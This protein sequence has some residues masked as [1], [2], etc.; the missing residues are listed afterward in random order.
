MLNFF[1]T[2]L[3][4]IL[5]LGIGGFHTHDD[6]NLSIS[7]PHQKQVTS[8]FLIDTDPGIDDLMAILLALSHES[9]E[10]KA[11]TL[12]HG[13]SSLINVTRNLYTLFHNIN[14]QAKATGKDHFGKSKSVRVALGSAFPLKGGKSTDAGD[15]YGQDG[16]GNLTITHPYLMGPNRE[17]YPNSSEETDFSL[18]IKPSNL[19]AVDEILYQIRSSPPFSLTILAL[20]PLTNIAKAIQKDP[21]T[22]GLVKRIVVMGGAIDVPGNMSPLAEFNFYVDPTAASV[23]FNATKGFKPNTPRAH[24]PEQIEANPIHVTL[25]P[26]DITHNTYLMREY[27]E[28]ELRH[29]VNS[30]PLVDMF[31]SMLRVSFLSTMESDKVDGMALHDPLAAGIGLGIVRPTTTKW[32]PINIETVSPLN[33]G[34]CVV[35]KCYNPPCP[36]KPDV[37][38]I[39]VC[40]SIADQASYQ[41][42]L[43]ENIFPN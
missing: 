7:V 3:L 26:L 41:K 21:I 15:F 29:K 2:L 39:E 13:D 4:L 6:L 12:T 10:V 38:Y 18:R 32:M 31:L 33:A 30:Q 23:V 42:L 34:A 5:L 19:D 24:N 25:I 35:D 43:L 8:P 14:N 36:V 28:K 11:I 16:I 20:G 17:Q 1:H 40:F 9:T 27:A 22:M 37:P